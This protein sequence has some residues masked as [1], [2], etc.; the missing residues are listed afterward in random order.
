MDNLDMYVYSLQERHT[1]RNGYLIET[2]SVFSSSIEKKLIFL[3]DS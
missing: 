1:Y 3:C 2:S